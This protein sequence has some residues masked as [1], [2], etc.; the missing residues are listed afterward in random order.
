MA[1]KDIGVLRIYVV[2]IKYD[3]WKMLDI[4]RHN[5][6]CSTDNRCGKNV[7]VI[8]IRQ[9]YGRYNPIVSCDQTVCYRAVHCIAR[10][11]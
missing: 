1:N 11:L 2:S 7:P 8:G 4:V 3:T 6:V 9:I 10:L 5:Y